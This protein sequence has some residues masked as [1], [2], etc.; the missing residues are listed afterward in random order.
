MSFLDQLDERLERALNI[1]LPISSPVQYD[2]NHG[3]SLTTAIA[4]ASA[5]SAAS[6]ASAGTGLVGQGNISRQES[7]ASSS[8]SIPGSMSQQPQQ[9]PQP[10]LQ[11]QQVTNVNALV[12]V[13]ALTFLQSIPRQGIQEQ[14]SLVSGIEHQVLFKSYADRATK[15]VH[16]LKSLDTVIVGLLY[17]MMLNREFQKLEKYTQMRL[18]MISMKRLLKIRRD[19][20]GA[21]I[22]K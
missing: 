5:A 14:F 8:T 12:P 13:S 16:F 3:N 9:Q 15:E 4:A 11:Y 22:L 2:E 20:H 7:A 21:L 6:V 18:L 19:L 17:M 10:T 1:P